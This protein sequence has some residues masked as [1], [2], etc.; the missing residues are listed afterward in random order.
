M[1]RKNRTE[2]IK[3]TVQDLKVGSWRQTLGNV[4]LYKIEISCVNSV[5][6]VRGTS[7]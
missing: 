5:M 2:Y 7:L 6:N 4:F 1:D 3:F